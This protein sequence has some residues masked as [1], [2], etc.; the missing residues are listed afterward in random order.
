[1]DRELRH[2]RMAELH[3]Q[4]ATAAEISQAVGVAPRS[5]ARWR[6]ATGRTHRQAYERNTQARDECERLLQEG[7]SFVEIGRTVGVSPSTVARWFPSFR[8]L[9]DT[10]SGSLGAFIANQNREGSRRVGR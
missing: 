4:G 1:M 8:G 5:V 9:S 6:K 7:I 3:D 10:E 2:R